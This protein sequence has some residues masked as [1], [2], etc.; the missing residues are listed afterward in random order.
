MNRAVSRFAYRFLLGLHPVSFQDEFGA[1]M[2]WIFEEEYERNNACYLFFGAL[3]SLL[4]Q[5]CRITQ[6][7]WS[8]MDYFRSDHYG[9]WNRA[10]SAASGRNYFCPDFL[11]LHAASGSAQPIYGLCSMVRPDALLYGHLA[12]AISR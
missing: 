3:M 8:V 4:R 2:L 1:E 6:R 10:R 11:Q 12:G 5:R 7:S 9:S